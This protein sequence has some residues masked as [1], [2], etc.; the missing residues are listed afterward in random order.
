MTH[1]LRLSEAYICFLVCKPK[2]LNI[3]LSSADASINCRLAATTMLKVVS[4]MR[5][6]SL[7]VLILGLTFQELSCFSVTTQPH[8]SP[9]PQVIPQQQ[10]RDMIIIDVDSVISRRFAWTHES[11]VAS[12]SLIQQNHQDVVLLLCKIP[13]S[14]QDVMY[15]GGPL[16]RGVGVLFLSDHQVLPQP[17]MQASFDVSVMTFDAS[18]MWSEETWQDWIPTRLSSTW[19]LEVFISAL[20]IPQTNDHGHDTGTHGYSS[21]TKGNT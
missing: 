7:H 21:R 13:S 12:A 6:F 2:L 8:A 10:R 3:V 11:L 17:A 20:D 18:T 9:L 4:S 15:T 5:S 14:Q 19:K 1:F 16:G